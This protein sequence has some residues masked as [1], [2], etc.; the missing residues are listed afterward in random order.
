MT[1]RRVI[2]SLSEHAE[3]AGCEEMLL[4][5]R[6]EGDLFIKTKMRRGTLVAFL[7]ETI[8]QN[9]VATRIALHLLEKG[10]NNGE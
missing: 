1:D 5:V 10:E 2:E 8:K 6:H 7:V 4:A 9:P 3:G